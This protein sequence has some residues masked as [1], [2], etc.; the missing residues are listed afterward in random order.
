MPWWALGNESVDTLRQRLERSCEQ[1]SKTMEPSSH[2]RNWHAVP[3]VALSG[4]CG[5]RDTSSCYVLARR[6]WHRYS[7]ASAVQ[8]ALWWHCLCFL[9]ET[10]YQ[11]LSSL[12]ST[13]HAHASCCYGQMG[14]SWHAGVC[15]CA[16]G[17]QLKRQTRPQ[18]A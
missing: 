15:P 18:P 17:G 1:V 10:G 8:D 16:R 5:C 4:R 14:R 3:K 11:K 12:C 13:S 7:F 9:H 6:W 2:R